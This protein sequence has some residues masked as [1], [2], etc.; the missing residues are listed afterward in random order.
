[1]NDQHHTGGRSWTY[2]QL[3]SCSMASS[4]SFT[5]RQCYIDQLL[6]CEEVDPAVKGQLLRQKDWDEQKFK[7]LVYACHE[8]RRVAMLTKREGKEASFQRF[9]GA[10]TCLFDDDLQNVVM[11]SRLSIVSDG[12]MGEYLSQAA[13]GDRQDM[14]EQ[15]FQSPEFRN[16]KYKLKDVEFTRAD[17]KDC[18]YQVKYICTKGVIISFEEKIL[19]LI[20]RTIKKEQ[21]D[22]SFFP[23]IQSKSGISKELKERRTKTRENLP[24]SSIRIQSV[25]RAVRFDPEHDAYVSKN[26]IVYVELCMSSDTTKQCRKIGGDGEIDIVAQ[27]NLKQYVPQ[28]RWS[29]FQE[30]ITTKLKHFEKTNKALLSPEVRTKGTKKL[31]G[32]YDDLVS[33]FGNPKT[34]VKI[35]SNSPESPQSP[36]KRRSSEDRSRGDDGD[37]VD[38]DAEEGSS[39]DEEL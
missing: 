5:Q 9:A 30:G 7:K 4:N 12:D 27:S 24:W 11:P 31:R 32:A 20:D 38:M 23:A 16:F 18:R 15:C 33:Y 22:E 3:A 34:T 2:P 29:Y 28:D 35:D 26:N 6:M 36:H 14:G 13:E 39:S 21:R 19:Y 1:M 37:D 10:L 8:W 25:A 17:I